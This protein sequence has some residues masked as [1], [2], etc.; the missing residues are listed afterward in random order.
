[1]AT[2]VQFRRGTTGE[3]ALFTGAVGEV[4]VDITKDTCVIHDGTTQGGFPLM[5]EDGTNMALSLGSLTSCALKF[6]NDPN[7]GLISPGTDQISLVAGGVAGIALDATGSVT[8]ANNVAIGGNLSVA[9]TI[10]LT[11]VVTFASGTA[12]APSITFTTDSNTGIYS[13]GADHLGF[14]TNGVNRL[15]LD[16]SG[17]ANFT[18]HVNIAS[19]KEYR[20]NGTKVLDATSLG[21]SV[22]TSSLTTVGTISTGVWQGT[23]ISNNYG[24]TGYTSYAPGQLLIGKADGSLAKAT[25]T[26]STGVTITNGDGTI[27]ISSVGLGGTVTAVT[28]STPLASTGGTPPNITIQDGT[29]PQKGAV[30]LE[31]SVSSAST[32]T[33]ATSHAVKLSYDL[34]N[35]ALPKTGGTMTGAILGDDSTSPATPGYAFDGDAN[36][37]MVRLGADELGLVTGGATRLSIDATGNVNIPGNLTIQGATTTIDSTTVLIE[38]KNIELGVVPTPTNTTADT[39]GII[40]K[41]TTDKTIQWLNATGAWTLSEHVDLASTKEYRIAGVKILDATS[42]GSGVINSSLSSVGNL[43][44]GTW[45]ASTIAHGYGGTGHTSYTAGQLLIG[46]ADGSLAKAT[47]TASTGVTITNGD[48][49]ITISATGSGGTVTSVTGSAPLASTG[50]NTPNLSLNLK[51]NGGLVTESNNLAVDLGA[52]SITGT[53]AVSDGGTGQTTYT[54]GQLLI[55]NSTGNTLS[56]STLTAG[57]GVTITNGAGT[58]TISAHGS[59][60]TITAVTATSPLAST[61]GTTPDISI[62]DGTTAQKGAVQLED[63]TSS[64]SITKAATPNSVKSAYDLANAALP[65]AGGTLTGNVT[66]N[67]QSDLRFADADSSNWVAFQAPATVTSNVTWTLPSAD[68]TAGQVLST[69]GAG[70]LSWSAGG[71]GGASVTTSDTAPATPTDGDLWYDSANGRMYVYYDDGNTSQWVDA[72][73][74]GLLSIAAGDT[75][76]S[77]PTPGTVWY[78]S[79]GGRTYF[80]YDDGNTS[81]WVDAS[82]QAAPTVYV[83][84]TPPASPVNG[85]FWYDSSVGRTYIYYNDGNTAQ[86]VDSSPQA[87]GPQTLITVGNTSAEVFDTGSNGRFVV[88]TEGVERLR[89][90]SSG[91]LRLAGSTSGYVGLVPAAVA[92]STTYTLPSADGT[93]GQLLST[94]GTGTLS[95]T[96][97]ASFSRS[98]AYFYSGF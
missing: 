11:G 3:T 40:L 36:T 51:A 33:A 50:G 80:Y 1:M 5:R 95:W 70:V 79:V 23:A 73:P 71:G 53:L 46:K 72:S 54:D 47:L 55:G 87:T 94:N 49:T 74:Q 9:G 37:G 8:L 28:A 4:T 60:G 97:P 86:W 66:L 14:A 92:G 96:T 32:T 83:A 34:A 43:T 38:D 91:T 67:A 2:Q 10:N 62:Q 6:A 26:A 41:G 20:I 82:P 85:G 77:A 29:P 39:G 65:K 81:Q 12:A 88:T 56:K 15:T 30:Q 48:G 61:G 75:P 19:T 13:P 58:I 24:G 42:L 90:D 76:P 16:S 57:S 84:D 21:S 89:V 18:G 98:K 64:T 45:Q 17:N 35:A 93:S 44:T 25:L 68:G 59:G 78:D 52:S 69:D 7:T 22:V 31:D 63:S 27:T